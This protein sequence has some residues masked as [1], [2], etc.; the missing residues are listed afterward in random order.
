MMSCFVLLGLPSVRAVSIG[1]QACRC[2]EGVRF[3][4]EECE[5]HRRGVLVVGVSN[6]QAQGGGLVH[7]L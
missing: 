5:V 6:G 1:G 7:A 3:Y 2:D 4:S